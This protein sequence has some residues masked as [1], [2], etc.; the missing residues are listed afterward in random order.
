MKRSL[1]FLLSAVCCFCAMDAEAGGCSPE[2]DHIITNGQEVCLQIG[3]HWIFVDGLLASVDGILVLLGDEW[4]TVDDA[5]EIAEYN[6]VW[7]CKKCHY[8]NYDEITRCP[9]CGKKRG[10]K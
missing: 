4:M 8:I 6:C 7:K 5:L 3:D 1:F 10:K 9:V 2:V